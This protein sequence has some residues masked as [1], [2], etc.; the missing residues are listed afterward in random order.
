MPCRLIQKA[1]DDGV[2]I[3]IV[4]MALL[5]LASYVYRQDLRLILIRPITSIVTMVNNLAHNPLS[6]FQVK[7][8]Q[9]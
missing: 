4:F 1:F 9:G 3:P 2:A 5:S 8:P 7:L 6:D